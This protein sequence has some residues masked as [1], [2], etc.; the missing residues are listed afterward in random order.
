MLCQL[1]YRGI[2]WETAQPGYA[3]AG[4]E[5][6]P[7]KSVSTSGN[8]TPGVCVTGRNVTNYTNVDCEPPA[9]IELATLRL[10]SACSARLSYR[11]ITHGTLLV[12][13]SETKNC[14]T[15]RKKKLLHTQ[16]KKIENIC[17]KVLT[18]KTASGHPKKI[19]PRP[20]IEPGASA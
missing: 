17:S 8:R 15:L 18:L 5:N 1:S 16:K 12:A 20:G 10:L 4:A 19:S 7:K 2:H 14:C 3:A 9:R 13:H 6:G 11:G